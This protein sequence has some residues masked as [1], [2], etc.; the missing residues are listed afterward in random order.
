MKKAIIKL[1]GI[2][3][4]VVLLSSLFI[5]AAPVS[6]ADP[7]NWEMKID[8]PSSKAGNYTLAP[9]TTIYDYDFDSSAMTMYAVTGTGV[10]QSNAGGSK[11]SQISSRLPAGLITS[12]QHVAMAPDDP[13]VVVVAGNT[14]AAIS[15]DGGATWASMGTIQNSSGNETINTILGL[16]ISPLVTGNYRYVAVYGYDAAGANASDAGAAIFYYNFGAGVG[17]WKEA[18]FDFVNAPSDNLTID[19]IVAMAFSPGFSADYMAVA[20]SETTGGLSEVGSLKQHI[21]SFNSRQWDTGVASGYPVNLVAAAAAATTFTVNDAAVAMHP[22]Y[23]GGDEALRITFPGASVAIGGTEAG[24]M[25]R[26]RDSAPAAALL[27][28]ATTNGVGISSVAFDGTNLAGGAYLTNNVYRSADPMANSPTVLPARSYKKIGIDDTGANDAVQIMFRGE[29]LYGAKMGAASAISKS[30]DY[31]NTWNDYALMDSGGGAP[32]ENAGTVT[33]ILVTATG[34]PWY[35]AANDGGETSVYRMSMMAAQ[36]VLCVDSVDDLMLRGVESNPDIVYAATENSTD[37]YYTADGGLTRWYKR[38]APANIVDMAVESDDVVYIGEQ[39]GISIY[40]SI[41]KGFTWSLPIDTKLGSG[42][43]ICNL[44]SIGENDLLVS[45][46]ASGLNY[47]Q[48]GG[49]TWTETLGLIPASGALFAAATGLETGDYIFVADKATNNVY[50]CEIGPSNPAGEFKTMN[51]GAQTAV[52]LNTGFVLRDGV[53]Y[54]LSAD[55]ATGSYINRTMA[56]TIPGTH[57]APFW[58]TRYMPETGGGIFDV[59]PTALKASSG[60]DSNI[61][62]YAVDRATGFVFYFD[63]TVALTGPI[64]LA[65]G[66]ESMVQMNS[67]TGYPHNVNFTWSRASKATGYEFLLALDPDF[68]SLVNVDA[69]GTGDPDPFAEVG[70]TFNVMSLIVPGDNFQPGTTYYWKVRTDTP[71]TGAFSEVRSFTVQPGAAAVPVIGSPANGSQTVGVNPAFSW[72]PVSGANM[73]EFQLAVSTNFAS[74][75]FSDTIAE[76]GIRPAVKLDQDT[77]YFWRVRAIDPVVGD[78]STIANF[79][80]AGE[81]EPAPP[82]VVIEQTPPPV[83]EIPPA[84]PAPIINI[85][86]APPATEPI[87]EGYILAIIIIGAILVIAVIILIV[88]TRRTV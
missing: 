73:Y 13:N 53:L 19:K 1:W 8:A 84:E 16:E 24:G 69:L 49:S 70:G 43:N 44:L 45:G 12:I 51:M 23:D 35:L 71:L 61:V 54:V 47:T 80:V 76:T 59:T 17:A 40:K 48:D 33:D 37:L 39:N 78:W 65:P 60:A 30:V 15:T 77:T 87:N 64:V 86:E 20:L 4:V 85:P 29:T 79:T 55:A 67:I 56:P 5:A 11:S 36:K 75:L 6:A 88:R 74:P 31:G 10:Y 9:G 3:L 83:I 50:R 81:E 22:D 14:K 18:L 7:L 58:G 62:L 66:D 57:S 42:N 26:C 41:T 82:P 2:G 68:T 27:G 25:W 38:T 72:S 34:D 46:T 32:F 28:G 21:L 63:D 52:E